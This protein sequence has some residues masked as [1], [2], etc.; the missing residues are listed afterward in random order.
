MYNGRQRINKSWGN[1]G[2]AEKCKQHCNSSGIEA[3]AS[4]RGV[5]KYFEGSENNY[6][7]LRDEEE[8]PNEYFQRRTEDGT[9]SGVW[10]NCS[11]L[12]IKSSC[13]ASKRD[14]IVFLGRA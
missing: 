14:L 13:R 3:H 5:V 4:E 12:F 11:G 10:P 9:H 6:H 2:V 7:Y 1:N 8:T